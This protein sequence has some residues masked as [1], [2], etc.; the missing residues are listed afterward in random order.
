MILINI[1]QIVWL[2][3]R[4]VLDNSNLI[5]KISFERLPGKENKKAP[6][7]IFQMADATF[8]FSAFEKMLL[9]W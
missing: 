9:F 1:F 6:W 4:R 7:I 5:L 3:R 2:M 8:L